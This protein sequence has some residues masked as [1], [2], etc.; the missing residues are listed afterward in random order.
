VAAV[1]PRRTAA[2]VSNGEQWGAMGTDLFADD[3]GIVSK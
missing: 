1:A 2:A 3:T